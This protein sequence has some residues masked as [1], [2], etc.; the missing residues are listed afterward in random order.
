MNVRRPTR[1]NLQRV[2]EEIRGG[3]LAILPTETVYGLAADATNPDAVAKIFELK[4][5]PSDNP[6]IVHV[7][8]V[9]QFAD[10]AAEIPEAVHLLAEAFMPGPLTLVLP[11]RSS[12]S[13]LITG[14]LDT[15]AIRIPDHPACL[16][17][18]ELGQL[19][20][21]MPSA[22]RFMALSPTN[23][24]MLELSISA[25]VSTIIDGGPCSIG[26]ESTVLDFTGEP[27]ILRPGSVGREEIEAA[28]SLRIGVGSDERKAPGMY[29]RHYSPRTPCSVRKTVDGSEAGLVFGNIANGDQIQ[30]P[31]DSRAY[32]RLLYAALA[33]L[34]GRGVSKFV[35]QAPPKTEDWIA[36]WDRISKATATI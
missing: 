5:R 31:A 7:S 4:G 21:A 10:F 12:V 15:V 35:I 14:G 18:M 29:R 20:L 24:D 33:D 13:G 28:L 32:A 9:E 23:V 2:A 27:V 25:G 8:S 19:A 36:V 26:I 11:K 30:M 17:V 16:A 34:D 1:E 3:Q 6:L 22:N